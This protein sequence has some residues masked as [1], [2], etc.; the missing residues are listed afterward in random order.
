MAR[1]WINQY[2]GEEGVW[3]PGDLDVVER[4]VQTNFAAPVHLR[5]FESARSGWAMLR[6][7]G[8]DQSY[9]DPEVFLKI[10]FA[11]R[12]YRYLSAPLRTQVD[13]NDV[14][15]LELGVLYARSFPGATSV[16]YRA[17]INAHCVYEVL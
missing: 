2:I 17:F 4:L 15:S 9:G 3:S 1:E 13:V 8:A 6:G 12:P 16:R 10:N 11:N 14:T 7:S 5:I